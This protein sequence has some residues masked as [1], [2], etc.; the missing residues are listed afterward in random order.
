MI[1][2]DTISGMKF[3]SFSIIRRRPDIWTIIRESRTRRMTNPSNDDEIHLMPSIVSISI[4][5]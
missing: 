1:T 4:R 3:I 2:I 5:F